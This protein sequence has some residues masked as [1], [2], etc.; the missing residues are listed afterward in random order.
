MEHKSGGNGQLEKVQFS[1]LG[2]SDLITI[3][4]GIEI[5]IPASCQ[6]ARVGGA[7]KSARSMNH[8]GRAS[9]TRR[10]VGPSKRPLSMQHRSYAKR[11]IAAGSTGSE[12]PP[13]DKSGRVACREEKKRA[14]VSVGAP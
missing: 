13:S 2:F 12:E 7:L 14:Y 3:L 6:S 11:V 10:A 5:P 4:H 1:A 8:S 9:A